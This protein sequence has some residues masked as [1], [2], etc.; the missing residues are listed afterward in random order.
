ML[1][2]SYREKIESYEKQNNFKESSKHCIKSVTR[3]KV[4]Q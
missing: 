3:R 4:Q 2:L 1:N